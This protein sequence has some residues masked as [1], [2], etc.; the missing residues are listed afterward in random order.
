MRLTEIM[1]ATRRALR[2]GRWCYLASF[3]IAGASDN[4]PHVHLM[5]A[6]RDFGIDAHARRVL[7][8]WLRVRTFS[9]KMTTPTGFCYSALVPARKGLPQGGILSPRMW[10]ALFKPVTDRLDGMRS[11]NCMGGSNTQTLWL[12]MTSHS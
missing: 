5:K 10:L 8:N 4:A 12:Q 6:M 2:R 9:V 7:R 3:D 1:D 11:Q